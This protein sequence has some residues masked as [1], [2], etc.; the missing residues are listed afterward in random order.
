MVNNVIHDVFHFRNVKDSIF[1][2]WSV[3]VFSWY[4]PNPLGQ[5][6]MSRKWDTQFKKVS[7]VNFNDTQMKELDSVQKFIQI[8]GWLLLTFSTCL[9]NQLTLKDTFISESCIEIKKL[10]LFS[11][12]ILKNMMNNYTWTLVIWWKRKIFI[13]FMKC[14]WI[15]NV[16]FSFNIYF[17]FSFCS[18]F[19]LEATFLKTDKIIGLKQLL[20]SCFLLIGKITFFQNN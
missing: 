18:D 11:T 4:I 6:S 8:Q 3:W 2:Y 16:V 17:P 20:T 15:L 5:I 13:Y 9:D 7:T 1:V 19:N 14:Y 10:S 12:R